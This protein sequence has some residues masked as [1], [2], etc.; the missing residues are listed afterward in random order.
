MQLTR[1][2]N[3]ELPLGTFAAR[4]SNYLTCPLHGGNGVTFAQLQPCDDLDG[5]KLAD[6]PISGWLHLLF[7]RVFPNPAS[8][9]WKL[10]VRSIV[11]K[12]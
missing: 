1:A 2:E 10:R 11:T 8:S 3:A 5:V 9:C 7:L 6:Q 12:M 4:C